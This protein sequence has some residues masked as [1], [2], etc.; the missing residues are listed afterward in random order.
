VPPSSHLWFGHLGIRG[1]APVF[2]AVCLAVACLATQSSCSRDSFLVVTLTANR[3]F[4]NVG[5]V[6]V[7]VQAAEG[8]SMATLHYDRSAS[9]ISF[10]T[11]AEP[12]KTLSIGF[13]PDRSGLV[14]LIVTVRTPDRSCI[15]GTG[16]AQDAPIKKGD[17]SSVMVAMLH[18]ANCP[19]PDGGTPDEGSTTDGPVTFAGCDPAMPGA[20]CATNQTCF[21]DCVNNRGM[22]VAGGTK[23]A[24]E[25]CSGN[26]DCMPG[27]QCFDYSTVPGCAA[28]TRV[29][30]KFC[31]A[32]SQCSSGV[33]GSGGAG[34]GGGSGGTGGSG[35][36]TG[37][38]G[39]GLSA[40]AC[41]DPVVCDSTVTTYKT[42][43]F[44]CDP[45]GQANLGCPAGLL[46]FLYKDPAGGPDSPNCSC[47]EPTRIGTN[48][49]PCGSS[50]ACAPGYICNMMSTTQVCRKLCKLDSPTDCVAP[51]TCNALQNNPFGVCLGGP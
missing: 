4:D 32:D 51:Q 24:G 37:G 33:M 34:G 31:A 48:G 2:V 8:P 16:S 1:R 25:T 10:G 30:L 29:C 42:C 35:G 21:V 20:M 9:P 27:T 14:N 45:R 3:A 46:C 43:S 12:S 49:V 41:R 40:S 6:D 11:V 44:G 15:I 28:G 47:R 26:A 23:G 39:S 38:T 22:C 36:A 13:T 18:L 19:N 17:I 5:W 7:E 50:A